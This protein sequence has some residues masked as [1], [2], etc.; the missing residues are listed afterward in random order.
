MSESVIADFVGKFNSEVTAGSQPVKGRVLLSE[1]RL[2]LAADARDDTLTVPLSRIFDVAVGHVPSDLG[3]FFDS[4]ITVAFQRNDRR[5]VTAIEADDEKIEKFSTVLFKAI[6]N[7]TDMTVKHPARVGG[8][9][10][11]AEFHPAKLFLKPRG[12]RFKRA[13]DVFTVKLANVTAFER[14]DREIA[15]STRQVLSV[16]HETRGQALTTYAATTSGR[17]MN[18]LGRYL[19][20]EYS[21]IREEIGDIS[22]S[23]DEKR[24]LVAIYSTDQGMP[25]ADILNKDASEVTMLL[26][27]LS[28]DGLV[29]DAPDGPTLTPKGK[30]LAG[31]HLEDINA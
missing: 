23:K 20:L 25:L 17:K 6:L 29:E 27:D 22:L 9:V 16:Q 3:D 8:R 13:D 2:V 5:Y 31:R 12:V 30:V 1:K 4:T 15:G 21:E 28:G 18:V 19:R 10:T 26:N 7:G 11:D 24:M 14:L